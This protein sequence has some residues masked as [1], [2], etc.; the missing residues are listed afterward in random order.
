MTGSLLTALLYEPEDSIRQLRKYYIGQ[1][2]TYS[3]QLLSP[4]FRESFFTGSKRPWEC[5]TADLNELVI[6]VMS[7]CGP[8]LVTSHWRDICNVSLRL[9]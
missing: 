9:T 1:C 8:V 6:R 5:P 4:T 3:T 7:K 2:P